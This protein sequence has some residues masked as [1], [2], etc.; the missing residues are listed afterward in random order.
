MA[1]S[2]PYANNVGR[3]GGAFKGRA[4]Q[5]GLVP[6]LRFAKQLICGAAMGR[7]AGFMRLDAGDFGAKPGDSLVELFDGHGVEVFL[8]ELD[9]RL[10]G[11]EV[12]FLVT[13]HATNR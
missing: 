2:S 4:A 3:A 6:A 5:P 9:D 1:M 10:A 11:L 8:A 7:R 12:V 13:C